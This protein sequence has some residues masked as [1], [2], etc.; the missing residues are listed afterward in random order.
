[1]TTPA[2]DA[3]D[4]ALFLTDRSGRIVMSDAA[5]TRLLELANDQ[6]DSARPAALPEWLSPI[7]EQTNPHRNTNPGLAPQLERLN[8]AGRF[9]FRAYRLRNV[10]RDADAAVFAISIERHAPITATI[11]AAAARLGLSDRQ[12]RVSIEMLNGSSYAQIGDALGIK[13]STV[14]D[15]VRRIYQK[16]GV[17]SRDEL[18]KKLV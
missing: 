7:L 11:V 16:L 2:S 6:F 15:H 12:R 1:M 10:R 4:S 18:K 3:P 17:H 9:V 14:V 8:E 13:E 5:T